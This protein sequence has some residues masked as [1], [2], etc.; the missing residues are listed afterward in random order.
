LDRSRQAWYRDEPQG[1][2]RCLSCPA[3]PALDLN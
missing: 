1:D 2:K 3:L